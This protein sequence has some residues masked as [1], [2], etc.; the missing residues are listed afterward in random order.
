[1]ENEC[2]WLIVCLILK[3]FYLIGYVF[4]VLIWYNVIFFFKIFF[5]ILL[6]IC[7]F[8]DVFYVYL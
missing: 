5:D 6:I 1:M 8:K 4:S 3:W 7:K 2:Y